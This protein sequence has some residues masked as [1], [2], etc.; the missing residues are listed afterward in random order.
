M[1]IEEESSWILCQLAS[2]INPLFNEAKSCRLVNTAKREDIISFLE[3]HHTMKYDVSIYIFKLLY[4][5]IQRLIF[6]F[7]FF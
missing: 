1:S 5:V 6:L 4:W 2:N 3:L 7:S